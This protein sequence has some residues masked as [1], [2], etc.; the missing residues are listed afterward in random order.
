MDS[1]LKLQQAYEEAKKV[2]IDREKALVATKKP[3]STPISSQKQ[4]PKDKI[5]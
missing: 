3:S 2:L 4:P 5:A 1:M